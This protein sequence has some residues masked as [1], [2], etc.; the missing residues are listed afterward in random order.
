MKVVAKNGNYLLLINEDKFKEN[1]NC[2]AVEF[3][4]KT[5]EFHT[6]N[7]QVFFKFDTYNEPDS[8]T[9]REFEE[10]FEKLD[11]IKQKKIYNHVNGSSE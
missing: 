8:E 6:E 11:E 1:P 4:L 2:P 3:N 10:V 9:Q 5:K 7:L